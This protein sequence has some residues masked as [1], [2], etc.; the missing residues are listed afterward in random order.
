MIQNTYLLKIKIG[1]F[2]TFLSQNQGGGDAGKKEV[3]ILSAPLNK[4][5][6]F[7]KV[8]RSTLQPKNQE[9]VISKTFCIH[10]QYTTK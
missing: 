2:H 4:H 9:S 8:L 3:A 6:F 7:L 10:V 5:F 1:I